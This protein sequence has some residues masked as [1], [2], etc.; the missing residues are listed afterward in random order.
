MIFQAIDLLDSKNG[1]IV[2]IL[3]ELGDIFSLI[4]KKVFN[5]SFL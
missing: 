3:H 5:T 1:E 4:A 2:E